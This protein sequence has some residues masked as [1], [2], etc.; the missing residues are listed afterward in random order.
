VFL[1]TRS[2][3]DG[4][5]WIC[6]P[7]NQYTLVAFGSKTNGHDLTRY[8]LNQ[9][10][11]IQ[12]QAPGS[13]L[14]KRYSLSNLRRPIPIWRHKSIPPQHRTA[15]RWCDRTRHHGGARRRAPQSLHKCGPMHRGMGAIPNQ[16]F[17]GDRE[18]SLPWAVSRRLLTTSDG[19]TRWYNEQLAVILV[20]R[21]SREGFGHPSYN[22]TKLTGSPARPQRRQWRASAVVAPSLSSRFSPLTPVGV[23]KKSS[24]LGG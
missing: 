15:D 18:R 5:D 17:G 11:L 14:S 2:C 9:D 21:S 19:G 1:T 10:R 24:W 23:A 22:A 8:A 13:N 4:S 3:A 20:V 6:N 7:A 16:G 12:K